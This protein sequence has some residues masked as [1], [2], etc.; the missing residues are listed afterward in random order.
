MSVDFPDT[1]LLEITFNAKRTSEFYCVAY[2]YESPDMQI[3]R[4]L[5][6]VAITQRILEVSD[7]I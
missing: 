1:N 4:S 5:Y 7:K 6:L 2:W 3:M